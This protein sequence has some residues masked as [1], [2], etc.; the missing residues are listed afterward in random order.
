MENSFP[1]ILIAAPTSAQKNYALEEYLLAVY[2]VQYPNFRCIL[3][4]NTEDNGENTDHI[5]K[6]MVRLFGNDDR[7]TAF[8]SDIKFSKGIIA[9][10]AKGHNDCRKYALENEYDYLLHLE[11]D[12]MIL[13]HVL[14][15]LLLRNKQAVGCSYY[16]DEG[17]FRRLMVQNKIYRAPGNIYHSNFDPHDDLPF[18]TGG[19]KAVSHIGLG[20]MLIRKDVLD[21]IPFR[22]V[23]GQ[24]IFPDSFW[25][26][27]CFLKRIKI[28]CDTDL[29]PLKHN[30]QNWQIDVETKDNKI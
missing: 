18:M 30:N 9:R 15:E 10:V 23:P 4:D 7:F 25:A 20:C 29:P 14:Q 6:T 16:R 19:L 17:R 24:R 12:V 27:D 5:N 8:K 22:Y 21:K 2:N 3:F 1:K 11:T 26:E 13:P 28:W